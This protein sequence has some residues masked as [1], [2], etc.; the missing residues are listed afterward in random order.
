MQQARGARKEQ[1]LL[2]FTNDHIFP[3]T[4]RLA[5]ALG[6]IAI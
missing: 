1:A 5:D 2:L 3:D 6:M 4:V